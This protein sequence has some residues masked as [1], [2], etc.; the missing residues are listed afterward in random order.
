MSDI[1]L[2]AFLAPLFWLGFVIGAL[3]I[4]VVAW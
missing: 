1:I 3:V 4:A 2:G